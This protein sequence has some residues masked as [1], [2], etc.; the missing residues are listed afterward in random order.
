MPYQAGD[1]VRVLD[2]E[3]N[4]NNQHLRGRIGHTLVVEVAEDRRPGLIGDGAGEQNIRIEGIPRILFH[5]GRFELVAAPRLAPNAVVPPPMER[6]FFIGQLVETDNFVWKVVANAP[7]NHIG[8]EIVEKKNDRF[9][10]GGR[11]VGYRGVHEENQFRAQAIGAAMAPADML[12]VGAFMQVQA[13]VAQIQEAIMDAPPL[14]FVARLDAEHEHEWKVGDQCIV[15]GKHDVHGPGWVVGY[16]DALVNDK[17]VLTV[18]R[19]RVGRSV[20]ARYKDK[21]YS[22]ALEWITPVGVAAP[23]ALVAGDVVWFKQHLEMAIFKDVEKRPVYLIKEVFPGDKV[24]VASGQGINLGTYGAHEWVLANADEVKEVAKKKPEV[25]LDPK[26]RADK[27]EKMLQ[28]CREKLA[29]NAHGVS[30]FYLIREDKKGELTKT[31]GVGQACH[32]D[33]RGGYDDPKGTPVAVIDSIHKRRLVLPVY[34]QQ[35]FIDYVSYLLTR[36]PWAE[37]YQ[38]NSFEDAE[39]NG[40]LMNLDKTANQLV[41]AC[42]AMRQA[43]EFNSILPVHAFLKAKRFSGDVCF[44]IGQHFTQDQHGKFAPINIASGHTILNSTMPADAVFKFFGTQQFVGEDGKPSYREKI[45]YGNIFGSI[46]GREE[47]ARAKAGEVD[48]QKWMHANCKAEQIGAGLDKKMVVT[49]AS[50][51]KLARLVKAEL[52]KHKQLEAVPQQVEVAA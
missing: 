52:L 17:T 23:R 14:P 42:I 33:L 3:K 1:I 46:T 35:G 27:L 47:Y 19:V 18:T 36:S 30:N 50:I 26:V 44:L 34:K 31:G 9:G 22:Y 13:A 29:E 21:E 38:T 32:Y 20:D 37:C 10:L 5:S 49:E 45:A 48:I 4:H 24:N 16:M 11:E 43:S 40:I 15:T 2:I 12:G 28:E 25:V 7:H 8:V 6:K 51:L 39:T 41:G